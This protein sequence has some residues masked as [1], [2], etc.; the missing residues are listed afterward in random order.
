MKKLIP[1]M[2]F[3]ICII[4]MIVI[5]SL[6]VFKEIIPQPFNYL[7]IVPVV[8]G[9]LMMM[10]VSK[11]FNKV[12][13]E[14]HTFRK[15]RRLVTDGLFKISRNPIY[16]GFAIM[17]VGV[18]V[19]LGTLLPVI[20]C[21]VFVVIANLWYIPYEERMMEQTFGSEYLTYKTKV[22]RWL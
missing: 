6:V 10:V 22:R 2:L 1:P 13:T 7:G 12:N 9:A 11:I 3:L 18:W 5:K 4:S 21:L 14:I 16:L 19:L 20:G 8:I 17:L 15:P